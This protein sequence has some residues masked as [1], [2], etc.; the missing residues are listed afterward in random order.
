VY[1]APSLTNKTNIM[2]TK[3]QYATK[4]FQL[5]NIPTIIIDNSIYLETGHFELE[6]SEEEISYRAECYLD[7]E[8]QKVN[9]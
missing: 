7:S 4:W 6:L 9:Q 5:Q 2:Q 1:I 8:K 3:L